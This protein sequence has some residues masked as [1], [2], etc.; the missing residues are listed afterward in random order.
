MFATLLMQVADKL[1]HIV[2]TMLADEL[3][4]INTQ[5][6]YKDIGIPI[7]KMGSSNI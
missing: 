1:P 6:V 4:R 2:N 5:R 3:G 7:M